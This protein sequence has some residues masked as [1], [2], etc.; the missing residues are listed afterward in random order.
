MVIG[1]INVLAVLVGTVVSMVLGFIW[2]SPGVF[3][4]QWMASTGRTEISDGG[5][6]GLYA[7]TA[8][9]ALLQATILAVIITLTGAT[10]LV[11]GATL[12]FLVWLG[13]VAT[14]KGV[15][16]L[17]NQRTM[18]FYAISSGYHLVELAIIGAIL[19][20]WR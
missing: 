6:P 2:Y 15:D 20:A 19:G 7:L 16:A 5:S 11:A 12:G 13:F 3:G 4:R 9:F 18:P 10:T 8:T 14:T 1:G 17:F